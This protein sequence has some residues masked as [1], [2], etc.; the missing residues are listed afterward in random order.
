MAVT[1]PDPHAH[2]RRNQA[3][4]TVAVFIGYASFT[5]VMPFLPLYFRDLGVRDTGAIAIWSGLSLGVT[6]AIT[7]AGP[8][9][10]PR[11]R[12]LRPQADGRAVAGEFCRGDGA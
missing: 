11:L 12:A 1:P 2:W 3:A 8:T 6:P 7:A 4:V 5:L 10:A 9:M